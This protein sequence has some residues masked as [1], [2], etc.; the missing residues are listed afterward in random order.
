[1]TRRAKIDRTLRQL[2]EAEL[3]ERL[4]ES[5]RE[6]RNWPAGKPG[7]AGAR[8]WIARYRGALTTRGL[9]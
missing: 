1:M 5:E 8:R 4:E 7:K 6:F 9:A 2:T 3:R